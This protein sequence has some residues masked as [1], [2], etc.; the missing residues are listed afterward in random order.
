MHILL[1]DILTCPR[2]GPAFGLIVLADR[3]SERHVLQG[4]LG[5]PNCRTEFPIDGGVA[6]LRTVPGP[7]PRAAGAGLDGEAALRLAALLGIGDRQGLVSVCG[8]EPE[9]VSAV[10]ELLP[11]AGVFGAGTALPAGGVPERLGWV[12]HSERLPFRDGALRGAALVGELPEWLAAEI[13]RV[14]F[15]GA[16]VVVDGIGRGSVPRLLAQGLELLLEQD[17]VAVASRNVAR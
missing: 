4:S 14:L 16:R 3:I 11:N 12:L 13:D 2:C 1:T 7:A 10:A 17:G 9:L 5:C 8:A 6:D 15:P